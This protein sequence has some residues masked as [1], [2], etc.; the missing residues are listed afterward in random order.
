MKGITLSLCVLL[1]CAAPA[2]N[3]NFAVAQSNAGKPRPNILFLF[4]DDQRADT[5]RALGNPYIAT[6]NLDGLVRE[7][8][9]FTRAY[10]MGGLQGAVCVPSR[11]MM[12]SG[13][14][15]FRIKENLAGEATWPQVFGQNGYATFGIGKWHNTPPSF[16][17]TFAEGKA[18]F[19][20]GMN[21]PYSMPV[22]DLD[23]DHKLVNQRKVEKH[24]TEV[25]TDAA[26]ELLQKQNSVQ[27]F[28]LYVAFTLPHDP[29]IA[30]K[31]F[32]AQ[33]DPAKLPLPKNFLPQ[34][35]FDN[36]EMTVR[37]ELLAPWPR[38]PELVREHLADYY[39]C[40]TYLDFQ[41]G[42]IIA[43]LKAT[44]QYDNTIIVFAGDHGLAIGSHG[45]F[46]K[47]NLYEHSM[48]TPLLI[49]GPGVPKNKRSDAFAYLLD[50]FPTLCDLAGLKTPAAVEG[51]SLA[52]VLSGK[53]KSRRD[54][55]FTAYR[56]VQ[57]AIR[58]DRWK[59]IVYPQI[60]KTQLFDL[61]NDPAE[62]HDLGAAPA[63]AK[64]VA[65]MT[66]RLMQQQRQYGDAQ[67]LT[68]E[69]PRPAAF[70]PPASNKR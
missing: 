25:F 17:N 5:I 54:T 20:G 53:Q 64:Q 69:N 43:A 44:G 56:D 51:L 3:S 14:T 7:G 70:T 35:P 10:C 39:A 36:G 47:Q 60:N 22:Q 50:L 46:G 19:F 8:T 30:P 52:P 37:D 1:I 27:P 33:Y 55:I 68:V 57:R 40:I 59:L 15:L 12:M 32:R 4:S 13:K 61:R 29:R 67:L 66:A 41:V 24:A 48:T 49:A 28:V 9:A 42:R 6:P 23:V 63:Q 18:V 38:T 21:D 62:L 11:A 58:D 65:A 16:I 31:E 2:A 45:L 34:H 26:I